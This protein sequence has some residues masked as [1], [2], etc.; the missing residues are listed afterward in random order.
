MKNYHDSLIKCIDRLKCNHSI[1]H[2]LTVTECKACC[3]SLCD[4]V[5]PLNHKQNVSFD[6]STK[7]PLSHC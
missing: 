3:L 2:S 1:N 5:S 6:P 4:N 7:I